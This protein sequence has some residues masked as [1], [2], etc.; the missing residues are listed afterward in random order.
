MKIYLVM[1][2]PHQ[3]A[4]YEV[5]AAYKDE[6]LAKR[7]ISRAFPESTASSHDWLYIKE[8]EVV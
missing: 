5:V 7:C 8:I 4:G 6:Q 2:R 1:Y 3:R